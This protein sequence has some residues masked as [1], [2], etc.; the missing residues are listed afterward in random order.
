MYKGGY[1]GGEKGEEGGGVEEGRERR[2]RQQARAER[3]EIPINMVTEIDYGGDVS[4]E[5]NVISCR[6]NVIRHRLLHDQC[7]IIYSGHY[8]LRKY[9]VIAESIDTPST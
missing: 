1:G 4:R 3:R 6:I 8:L 2:K 5:D 9:F 7:L